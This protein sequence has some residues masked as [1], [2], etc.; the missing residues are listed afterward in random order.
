MSFH[1]AQQIRQHESAMGLVTA[2]VRG[3]RTTLEIAQS[4]TSLPHAPSYLKSIVPV[5]SVDQAFVQA[6]ERKAKEVLGSR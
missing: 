6:A 4:F 5:R 2:R 3:A 1:I